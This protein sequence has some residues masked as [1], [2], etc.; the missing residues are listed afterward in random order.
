MKSHEISVKLI[1]ITINFKTQSKQPESYNLS[2]K[3]LLDNNFFETKKIEK[4][5]RDQKNSLA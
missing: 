4:A 2:S 3:Y 5:A 1:L